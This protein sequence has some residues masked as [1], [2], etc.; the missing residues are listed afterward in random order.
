MK[1]NFLIAPDFPPERFAAWHMLNTVL[2]SR[3]ALHLHLLMPATAQEQAQM[4][5]GGGVDLMYANPF[6]ATALMRRDGYRAL[7]RPRGKPD[8]MVIASA[9]GSP[10]KRVE[11]LRRGQRIAVTDNRDVKLIGLRL[12]EPA[13]LV[14]AD[15]QWVPAD[16]LQGC[17]RMAVKGEVD[18]AFFMADTF[19]RLSRITRSQL[20][21]V[22]ESALDDITHVLL[23]HPKRG[24]EAAA[25]LTA[26]VAVGSQASD[27]EVLEALGM[28]Q[29]FEAMSEE[30]A[31]FMLDLMETLVD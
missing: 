11:D 3:S 30:D 31:E 7:A 24:A 26:L 18:A 6:D 2:Q 10:V 14:E 19:H 17:A 22:I 13:D 20:Q 16:T 28:A 29:G 9:L 1:L 4:L 23:A 12:I 27:A 5:D 15:L 8:E 21:V 25:L